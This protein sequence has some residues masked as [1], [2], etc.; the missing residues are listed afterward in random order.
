[1]VLKKGGDVSAFKKTLDWVVQIRANISALV[2]KKRLEIRDLDESVEKKE[3]VTSM[4][5]ELG[6]RALDVA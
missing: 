3:V 6:R 4:C 1:M 5:L 2:S